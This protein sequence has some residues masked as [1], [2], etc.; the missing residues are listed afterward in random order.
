MWCSRPHADSLLLSL[1]LSVVRTHGRWLGKP[2]QHFNLFPESQSSIKRRD[3]QGRAQKLT[4][5]YTGASPE[6]SSIH[7]WDVAPMT[8]KRKKS[9]KLYDEKQS[10]VRRAHLHPLCEWQCEQLHG[11][12]GEAL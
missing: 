9:L 5:M 12:N 10:K 1:Y 2:V 3:S 11:N 7:C 4:N 6:M 8:M